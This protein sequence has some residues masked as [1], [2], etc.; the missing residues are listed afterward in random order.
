MADNNSN[1]DEPTVIAATTDDTL[2]SQNNVE[3]KAQ[4]VSDSVTDTQTTEK[5][6]THVQLTEV[7]SSQET[8]NSK[9]GSPALSKREALPTPKGFFA[10]GRS[11]F[12]EWENVTFTVKQR[13]KPKPILHGISGTSTPGA[14]LALMGSVACRV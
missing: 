2:E 9:S 4:D 1:A 12:L 14:M 8:S 6:G 7:V 5:D 13:G 10:R 3:S 11:S